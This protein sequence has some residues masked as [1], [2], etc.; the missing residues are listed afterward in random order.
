[1][2]TAVISIKDLKEE[3]MPALRQALGAVPGV[4]SVDFSLE[5]S[6]AVV[7][8]DGAQSKI[9]DLMRAVLK[10]GYQVF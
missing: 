8:F 7:E 4:A 2:K 3:A 1:M 5:R 10:A 6:V 9:D